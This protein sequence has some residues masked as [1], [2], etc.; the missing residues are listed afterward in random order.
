MDKEYILENRHKIFVK[1]GE[2]AIGLSVDGNEVTANIT[3]IA[4]VHDCINMERNTLKNRGFV[5]ENIDEFQLLEEFMTVN[6]AD[7]HF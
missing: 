7:F 2:P 1:W 5:V 4:T 3:N 6:W